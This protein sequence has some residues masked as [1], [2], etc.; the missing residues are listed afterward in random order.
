MDSK[1]TDG[2]AG[3]NLTLDSDGVRERLAWTRRDSEEAFLVLDRN[4][5]GTE[6]FGNFTPQPARVPQTEVV[7]RKL[8]LFSNTDNGCTRTQPRR[9]GA[10]Y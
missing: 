3:A 9:C 2:S 7:K 8:S 4:G 6:L 10:A 5:N 1:L